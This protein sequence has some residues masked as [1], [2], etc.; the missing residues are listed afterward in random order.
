M[1][2]SQTKYF[3][4]SYYLK[5][6]DI[7][8]ILKTISRQREFFLLGKLQTET[9]M[10]ENTKKITPIKTIFLTGLILTFAVSFAVMNVDLSANAQTSENAQMPPNSKKAIYS[11]LEDRLPGF[12]GLF[13]DDAGKLNVYVTDPSKIQSADASMFSD[14]LESAH[15]EKGIVVLQGKQPWHQWTK[16]HQTVDQLLENRD[17]GVTMTAVDD[18][19]QALYIGFE[20]L[21]DEKRNTVND[22]L[23]KHNI[24]LDMVIFDETGKLT[25]T[26]HGVTLTSLKGGVEIQPVGETW[27]CTLGFIADKGTTRVAITAGHCESGGRDLAGD[28]QFKHPHGGSVKGTEIANTNKAPPRFSD[29]LLFAPS[30]SSNKGQIYVDGATKTVV[31]ETLS[32]VQNDPACSYGSTS[33]ERCGKITQTG[34]SVWNGGLG[35]TLHGQAKLN[36]GS[37][38]GDSGGP[39][40]KKVT[41]TTVSAMGIIWCCES[42]SLSIYSP[43]SGVEFDQG[44]LDLT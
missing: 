22:F 43:L 20:K 27:D 1:N 9:T 10:T 35:G 31:S 29:T 11:S 30:I 17:L 36:F 38:S 41:D 24:P 5:K 26:S 12:G 34:V 2:L 44:L 37:A 6:P 14:K 7:L 32:Q 25:P 21:D 3:V 18:M 23:T 16:W 4:L 13:L 19:N 15:L 40:Y 8:H 28:Q 42:S 39:V 33:H